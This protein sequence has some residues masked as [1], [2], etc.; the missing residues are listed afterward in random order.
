MNYFE[1]W[2]EIVNSPEAAVARLKGKTGTQTALGL[3]LLI[4][5]IS[6]AYLASRG[7]FS[8]AADL[9]KIWDVGLFLASVAFSMVGGI[10]A[11]LL[12]D[13]IAKRLGGKGSW[14]D[15]PGLM[16]RF[17]LP[18]VLVNFLSF[19]PCV[20]FLISLAAGLLG[21]YGIYISY[22]LFR[23]GYGLS[24]KRA[25]ATVI[26]GH[27]LVAVL[28][29]AVLVAAGYWWLTG[30]IASGGTMPAITEAAAGHHYYSTL[31]GGYSFDYPFGWEAGFYGNVM[32]Q[33]S[34]KL[35]LALMKNELIDVEML[36][37]A[38]TN[39]TITIMFMPNTGGREIACDSSSAGVSK[40]ADLSDAS[41]TR[42]RWG[43]LDGCLVEKAVNRRDDSV[44]T[45][46]ISTACPKS[47]LLMMTMTGT[48]YAPMQSLA[49]SFRCG[50]D[51]AK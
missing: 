15:I 10:L 42:T 37:N 41:F 24:K 43:G 22:K 13:W 51:A 32:N 4:A 3:M 38:R 14:Q 36:E 25:I 17:S 7:I 11:Y 50:S 18:L 44:S 5:V 19:I 45:V 39:E 35:L 27:L 21:I 48:E 40:N 26:G 9:L 49:E 12:L 33:S 23:V 2:K 20:G 47:R 46:F 1:E 16:C 34:A 6:N 30:F 31:H 28:M 8:L 29:T